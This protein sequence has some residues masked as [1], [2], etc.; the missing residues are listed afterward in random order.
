M[1]AW[2][3]EQ[4]KKEAEEADKMETMEGDKMAAD[5]AM[6]AA[7][8]AMMAADDAM[9]DPP[10]EWAILMMVSAKATKCESLTLILGLTPYTK[11]LSAFAMLLY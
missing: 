11:K 4:K 1:K 10:M 6:M 9:M 5:D 2:D 8:D 7:D 3:E